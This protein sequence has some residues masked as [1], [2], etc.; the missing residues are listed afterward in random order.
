[1]QGPLLR[2]GDVEKTGSRSDAMSRRDFVSLTAAA[3]AAGA[4]TLAGGRAAAQSRPDSPHPQRATALGRGLLYPQ[5]SGTRNLLDLSGLWQFQL[6]PREEGEAAGWFRALPA[7][8]PIAVPCS[9]NDL[10]D[11]AK[12]YLGL[13]WYLYE[14]WVPSG[15]RGERVFLRVGSANYAAKVWVNGALVAEHLGGHLPF[16]ADVTSQVVWDQP[17]VIAITVENKQLPERVPPGPGPAGGGVAGVL[18][19]FP[20]TTYDFFPYAGLHRQV[21]LYSVP[22]AAHID[23][24][25]VVT[26]IDGGDGVV[27]V[28]VAT[29]GEYTGRGKARLM[30]WKPIWT[31]AP[32]PPKPLCASPRRGS[33][34]R[35][36]HTCIR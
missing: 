15:W 2:G 9:W 5:Q 18:G 4:A 6:D 19:G 16:V 12:N 34:V 8:R 31:S 24:V 22:A 25:T 30:T 29:A 21:W 28:E 7:P 33:G 3:A 36:I 10:F 26:T 35:R 20:A 17:N 23:D 11:D 14:V 1:M 32:A 13:A 27:D